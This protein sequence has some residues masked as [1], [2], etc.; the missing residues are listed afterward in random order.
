VSTPS[1]DN[2]CQHQSGCPIDVPWAHIASA[3]LIALKSMTSVSDGN[4]EAGKGLSQCPRPTVSPILSPCFCLANVISRKA[5]NF[6][7]VFTHV[8]N[9]WQRNW[10]NSPVAVPNR[11]LPRQ[12]INFVNCRRLPTSMPHMRTAIASVR[13]LALQPNLQR[14]AFPFLLYRSNEYARAQPRG[15]GQS[16]R[17]LMAALDAATR[18]QLTCHATQ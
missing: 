2:T 3:T 5:C 15:K 4:A 9:G 11:P 13:S 10:E 17:M 16:A 8:R 7:I 14:M 12:V 1:T 18:C 6:T